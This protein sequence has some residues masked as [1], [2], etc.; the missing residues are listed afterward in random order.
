MTESLESLAE[1]VREASALL[2]DYAESGGA[3]SVEADEAREDILAALDTIVQQARRA[4]E[5]IACADT[6]L[7]RDVLA[8]ERKLREVVDAA[9]VVSQRERTGVLPDFQPLADAL[10]S[11]DSE[12]GE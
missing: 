9:R 2:A 11:L 12:A 5:A 1:R 10:R 8:R 4:E 7:M 6:P 3:G